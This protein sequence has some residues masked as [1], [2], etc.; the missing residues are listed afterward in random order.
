MEATHKSLLDI[1]PPGP[2]PVTL[3]CSANSYLLSLS[4]SLSSPASLQWAFNMVT[5][6]FISTTIKSLQLNFVKSSSSSVLSP[7]IHITHCNWCSRPYSK[8]TS[9]NKGC[10]SIFHIFLTTHSMKI[11][12][13]LLV[14]LFY[15]S[16]V[17]LPSHLW[18]NVYSPET[19]AWSSSSIQICWCTS[20]FECHLSFFL[21]IVTY[22]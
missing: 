21:L 19:C 20:R 16:S 10:F 14:F 18:L 13:P 3:H 5:S 22:F 11:S 9:V 8:L 4:S 7:T 12:P 2:V 15:F 1:E 17:F 6:L